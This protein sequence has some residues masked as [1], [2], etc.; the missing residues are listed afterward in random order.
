MCIKELFAIN[1]KH[2]RAKKKMSQEELAYKSELHRTYIS[3]VERQRR[4]ISLNNIEKIAKALEVEV[5]ELFTT[6]ETLE[7]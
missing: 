6:K 5:Y 7:D 2:Y 3:A 4:S 1:I